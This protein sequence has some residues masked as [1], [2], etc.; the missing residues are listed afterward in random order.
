MLRASLLSLWLAATTAAAAP[1]AAQAGA[2]IEIM[3]EDA[4]VP[5]SGPDGSGYAN[6]LVRAAF[7]AVHTNIKL[8]VVPYA[9]CKAYVMQGAVPA[10]FSMSP[11][12]E[13]K[14]YVA[15]SDQP[16]FE[17]YPRYYYNTD[18]SLPATSEQQ[19]APGTR[20]GIVNGY[21]YPA[22]LAEV[23]KRGAVLDRANSEQANLRK[24][25]AGRVDLALMMANQ[26]KTDAAIVQQAQVNNVGVAFHATPMGSYIGFSTTHPQGEQARKL[27]NE[28][29]RIISSNGRKNEIVRRWQLR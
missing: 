25:S 15:L 11:A 5:W 18:R 12:P 27:F 21:E 2:S 20:I 24:L 28:G 8:T 14:G 19:I 23:E 17:V 3:V 22:S 10:C 26:M 9:R 1:P 6:D 29:Y 7:E 16:L 13:Q 4:A